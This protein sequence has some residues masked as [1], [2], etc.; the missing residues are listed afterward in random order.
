M[1][2]FNSSF[3]K[4]LVFLSFFFFIFSVNSQTNFSKN[5]TVKEGLA[6]DITYQMMK[7]SLGFIYI[8]TD[9]G[10]SKFD[11]NTF[12][13]IHNKN[14]SNYVIDFFQNEENSLVFCTWGSGL[15]QLNIKSK[16]IRN[17]QNTPLKIS[18][19][20]PISDSLIY[21]NNYNSNF[22]LYNYS[23]EKIERFHLYKHENKYFTDTIVRTNFQHMETEEVILDGKVILLA[24][25]KFHENELDKVLQFD[26][27]TKKISPLFPK[28]K[29]PI[30]SI[31]KS[32][33][34]IYLSSKNSILKVENNEIKEQITFDL[35]KNKN[36]YDLQFYKN[37]FYF[38]VFDIE[39]GERKLYSY[40]LDSKKLS[41]ISNLIGISSMI[42]DFLI[43]EYDNIW[44]STYGEGIFYFKNS[45]NHFFGKEVFAE[46]ELK[47]ILFYENSF[48]IISPNNLYEFKNDAVLDKISL[49][50]NGEKIQID[51]K[52]Q[53]LIV[54]SQISYKGKKYKNLIIQNA[55]SKSFYFQHKDHEIVIL[56]NQISIQK[57]GKEIQ[58]LSNNR[59]KRINHVLKEGNF[60]YVLY[61]FEG[62]VCYDLNSRKIKKQWNQFYD[63]ETIK[64]VDFFISENVIWI[65]T[66]K[67]LFKIEKEK[68]LKIEG[69][70][71]DNINDITI[72]SFGIVWVGNQSGLN[73][74]KNEKTYEIGENA[75]QKSS[76]ISNILIHQNKVYATGNKGL[77]VYKND[78]EFQPKNNFDLFIKQEKN[79]FYFKKIN[80]LNQHDYIIQYQLDD[81]KKWNSI[82]NKL[83]KI[84]FKK[85]EAGS[86]KILFRFREISGDWKYGEKFEF[87]NDFSIYF[88]AIPVLLLFIFIA[89]GLN[90]HKK[91]KLK[92]SFH[93]N[94]ELKEELSSVRKNLAQ[95]FHDELGN[96]IANIS[97]LSSMLEQEIDNNKDRNKIKKIKEES[98]DLY[99]NVKNMIWLFNEENHTF[100]EVFF[101]LKDF[102]ENLFE[103]SEMDFHTKIEE[104]NFTY[105]SISLVKQIMLIFKEAMTNVLKHS[106]AKN[107]YFLA[108]TTKNFIRISCID[109][110][111][112]FK[113]DELKRKNGLKNMRIRSEK[114]DAKLEI[115]SSEEIG[116]TIQ[117]ELEI[118]KINQK[119]SLL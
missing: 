64:Y 56:K 6:H 96:K 57:D 40:H 74:I 70:A 28:I 61:E 4:H 12:L 73:V 11:G 23:K 26:I 35:L 118:E 42:S 115:K 18:G 68:I 78:E 90:Y 39:A 119:I 45:K 54:T 92:K 63:L 105:D 30:H 80:F 16:K 31:F 117:L 91:R 99:E 109:D 108:E 14:G 38:L 59:K 69:L 7:D 55:E 107:V 88:K 112:G 33:E 87:Q 2:T 76:I 8:G 29:Q 94:I 114:M 83:S 34:T 21:I 101:Y 85:L 37:H 97:I 84:D 67:G 111:K 77:F 17:L 103:D 95:D 51:A 50:Y 5:Y 19:I 72:D 3:Q 104:T 110:G 93:Q 27:E 52:N 32:K 13:N 22:S 49:P 36:I 106:E 43:D 75:L 20:K 24:D 9:N 66:T 41:N 15:H 89:L 65:A 98:S 46:K 116:T 86:H 48:L 71:N 100:N 60:L 1:Q 53:K 58:I 81:S 102:G 47:E 44:I 82:D 10:I 62:L 25:Y 113:I 79:I